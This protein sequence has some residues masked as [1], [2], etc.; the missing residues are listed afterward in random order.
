M[1]T[2]ISSV[3]TRIRSLGVRGVAFYLTVV[4]FLALSVLFFGPFALAP[5]L[6]WFFLP[7]DLHY[8]HDMAFGAVLFV[9]VAGMATQLYRP[10]REGAAI[11]LVAFVGVVIVAVSTAIDGSDPVFALLVAGLPLLALALHPAGRAV[12]RLERPADRYLGVLTLVAA[13][14]LLAFAVQQA[15]LQL[16]ATDE[17]AAFLHYAGMSLLS[18]SVVLGGVLAAFGSRFGAWAAGLMM[19]V[20]G[21]TS[22]Q[23]PTL[24][25]SLGTTV[26][27]VVLVGAVAFVGVEEYQRFSA[28]RE[29]R[30]VRAPPAA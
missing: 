28:R 24:A 27:F 14:P 9:M 15:D 13:V 30:T 6:G 10:L 29:R 21:L 16:T 19:A 8:V 1:S 11:V 26:G 22:I 23:G 2:I 5:L 18:V 12:F 20:F 3:S 4:A 25:S 17:H 7:V